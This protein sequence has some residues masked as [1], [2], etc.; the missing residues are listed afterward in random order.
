MKTLFIKTLGI[1][2]TGV[3]TLFTDILTVLS[4]AE[5]GFS[6]AIAY[7]LY[8]PLSDNDTLQISKI[9]NVYK[10]VYRCVAGGILL[11][12]ICCI[13]FLGFL[14]KDVPDIKENIA[15]IFFL[16]VFKTSCSYLLIYKA[17]LL[18][19]NQQKNIVHKISIVFLVYSTTI[20]SVILLVFNNYLLYLIIS[21]I[22]EILKNFIISKYSEKKFPLLKQPC[23]EKLSKPERK[24]MFGNVRA[25]ALYKISWALQKG[26]DSIVI[27]A[28]LGTG[29]VGF[30]SYY[31]LIVNNIDRLFG[32][33]F[34]AMKPSVGNLAAS[35][36]PDKQHEVFNFMSVASFA[37]GNFISV[38]LLV[39]INPFIEIWLGKEYLLGMDIVCILTVNTYILTMVRPYECF[40]LAN[41]LFVQ[42]K[43]RP[44]IM[45][46]INLGLAIPFA[47][48]WGIFGVLLAT[49]VS[50]VTTHVW[51]DP[52][53]IY[54]HV[55][56][57]PFINYILKRSLYLCIVAAN[58]AATF[59]VCCFIN[60][61]AIYVDFIIK[62][63]ICT[64]LPNGI[65]WLLF[66]KTPEFKQGKMY[67][68]S[69]I[70]RKKKI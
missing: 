55:F 56:H 44:V 58:C 27:S 3:S 7:A 34:E 18:E 45:F 61:G 57:R 69:L 40:R 35:E 53:L 38:A 65:F 19:A 2:Y 13:P 47:W 12:G 4:V 29:M 62:F 23:T 32:Q 37:I 10:W 59:F 70:K 17:T 64:L 9:M 28:L 36:T 51:Y 63:F 48:W 60:T 42:G 50:R 6:T 15:L 1:Q 43:Y 33:V 31:K 39:L 20:E 41:G 8:R 68:K 11:M 30:L 66:H 46:I 21:V 67:V 5:L 24:E 22:N 25:L 14:V 26:L 52:W 49:V 16:F 54:K